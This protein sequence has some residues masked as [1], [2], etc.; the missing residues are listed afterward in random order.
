VELQVY[1][2]GRTRTIAVKTSTPPES[3]GRRSARAWRDESEAPAALGI[4]LGGTPSKR[5]ADGVFL[6]GVTDNGPAEKAGIVE[7]ERVQAINGVDLRVAKEDAGDPAASSAKIARLRKALAAVK[8]GD[9]VELKVWSAGRTR[10]VKV[11]TVKASELLSERR[12]MMFD[13]FTGAGFPQ[14]FRMGMPSGM[15]MMPRLPAMPRTPAMPSLL[16]RG[17]RISI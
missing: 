11:K 14:E 12:P 3:N 1:A 5:D 7:G 16:R 15:T 6:S 10:S 9:D 13:G 2:D 17:N 4:A 8:V